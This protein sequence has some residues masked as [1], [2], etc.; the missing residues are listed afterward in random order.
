[1]TNVEDLRV[2]I[3]AAHAAISSDDDAGD[4]IGAVENA[5][6]QIERVSAVDPVLA[7]IGET[8][9]QL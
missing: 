6:R 2:A 5:R 7:K 8:L 4:A 1:M 3:A 9:V